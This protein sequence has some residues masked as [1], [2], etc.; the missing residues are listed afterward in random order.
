MK[1]SLIALAVLGAFAG[2]ASAQSSV[3]LYGVVDVNVQRTETKEGTSGTCGT[4]VGGGRLDCT[5][6]GINSGH[7]AGNR[8][9]L[10][11]SEDLGGGLRAIFQ[12]ESGFALDNGTS[13]QGNRLFG[14]QAYVGLAGGFGTLVA[15]RLATFA[16]GTGSFDKFGTIDPFRTGYGIGGMQNTFSSSNATRFDNTIAYLTPTMGGFSAGIGHTFRV[17]GGEL[18]D[19]ALFPGS[20]NNNGQIMYANFSAG[21]LYVVLTYD[22]IKL[23]E[24]ANEP[25]EKHLQIGAAYDL[26][27]VRLSAGYAKEDDVFALSTTPQQAAGSDATAWIIGAAAPFGPHRL[28]ASYQK[29]DVDSFTN[30][31]GV[32]TPEG[33]RKVWQ[34][35]YE[36]SL[37]RRTTFYASYA[38]LKD[39]G[40]LKT[41]TN[42]GAKQ[43]TAGLFHSF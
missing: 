17:N 21:P 40:S 36:Y 14:R 37:S 34:V 20:S 19:N 3:T 41:A 32:T 31:L 11:G 12:L 42:G 39:D 6:T 16:S 30:T 27:V 2:A 13:L 26:K 7:L 43:I 25:T 35:G 1:K 29:R 18:A 8:W 15:G 38:D 9:G 23:G 10:R 28:A 24:V 4:G 33:D 22:R 5:V